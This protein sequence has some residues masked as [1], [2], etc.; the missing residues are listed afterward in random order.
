[1]YFS[2]AFLAIN[3]GAC[4]WYF[5]GRERFSFIAMRSLFIRIAGLAAIF[6]LL[7][8]PEDYPLYYAIITCSAIATTLWNLWK[9][10]GETHFSLQGAEWKKHLGK[11]SV[12]YGISLLYS[13][14]LYIDH[15]LLRMVST[16]AAVGFYTFSIKLLRI[17]TSVIGDSMLV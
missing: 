2:V 4:E 12:T 7:K 14:T 11:V 6:I 10:Y 15:V 8:Q 1:I 3:A 5:I 17:S 16:A 13:I 9:L